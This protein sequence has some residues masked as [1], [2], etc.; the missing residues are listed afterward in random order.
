MQRRRTLR[1][2]ELDTTSLDGIA[3][4]GAFVRYGNVNVCTKCSWVTTFTAPAVCPNC[5]GRRS[6]RAVSY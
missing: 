3:A 2:R 5:D 6:P 1:P 4:A